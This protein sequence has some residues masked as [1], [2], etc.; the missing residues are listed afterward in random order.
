MTKSGK[1]QDSNNNDMD[2]HMQSLA[3]SMPG[4]SEQSALLQDIYF[5]EGVEFAVR[6]PDLRV[7]RRRNSKGLK[8]LASPREQAE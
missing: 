2:S 6:L 8:G 1:G 4:K 3:D 7:K 5:F